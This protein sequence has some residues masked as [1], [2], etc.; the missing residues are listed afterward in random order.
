MMNYLLHRIADCDDD[1][2]NLT[3]RF[4]FVWY[5][6]RSLRKDITQQE[7]CAKLVNLLGFSKCHYM[8]KILK[9]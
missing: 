6:T 8:I 2:N 1:E 9:M 3:D 4:H 7:L 5:R